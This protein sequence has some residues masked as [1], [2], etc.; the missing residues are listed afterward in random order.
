MMTQFI[1]YVPPW[2]P[3]SLDSLQT[4]LKAMYE[5]HPGLVMRTQT[6]VFIQC[7]RQDLNFIQIPSAY[8][9]HGPVTGFECRDDMQWIPNQ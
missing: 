9:S 5:V 8:L 3:A 6:E 4:L 1:V 2:N 7:H